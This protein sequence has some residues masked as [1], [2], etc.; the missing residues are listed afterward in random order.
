[1]PWNGSGTFTRD[2][3]FVNDA[4]AGPPDHFISADKVDDEFDNYKA[5]L[6][7][8]LTRDG[9]TS[10]SSSLPMGNYRHTGVGNAQARNE[11]LTAG[12][13]QDQGVSYAAETGAADA[14]VV[15]L[16]PAPTAYVAG[17]R[18]SFKATNANTGASTLKLGSLATKAIQF[19]GAALTAGMIPAN[20]IVDV[21][22]DGTQ[23]QMV[24]V[25]LAAFVTLAG[26]QSVGGNK[27]FTGNTS[28]T[29][30][31]VASGTAPYYDLL[32]TD[33]SSTRGTTRI[34]RNNDTLRFETRNS[35][36]TFLS[37]DYAISIDGNGAWK[38][39]WLEAGSVKMTLDGGL[40]LGS[41][42]G[43]AKGDGTMSA[44]AV[45]DDNVLLTCYALEAWKNG[46]QLDPAS[47]DIYAPD[48]HTEAVIEMVDTG[49]KDE[50]GDPI[51]R[52]ETVQPET[53]EI[54]QHFGA[55]KFAARIN[56]EAPGYNAAHD[57]R[58]FAGQRQ[59]V[60]DKGHLTPFPNRA[61]FDPI[62]DAHSTGEELQR[63]TE[64]ADLTFAYVD[65]LHGI[66]N[67][68]RDRVGALEARF[69]EGA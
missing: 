64:W 45:Y 69:G 9:Q 42:T 23:W 5:G 66:I 36:G 52:E 2:Q 15:T 10:P 21:I 19:A 6:E 39:E 60:L 61:D 26:N 31:V 57:P 22:Y 54:R 3:N 58:T 67:G 51:F 44:T 62:A 32:E 47:W 8:C 48:R 35:S 41:P 24:S 65:E 28:F 38:H 40:V 56:P 1:M 12:Q 14:Y 46:W 30:A 33:A 13:A 49:L 53:V 20:G 68:L 11:Y 18:V 27:S 43:G 17:M 59:H 50:H 4:A 25:P 63:L 7:N 16:S 34:L 55:H 37:L 29:G